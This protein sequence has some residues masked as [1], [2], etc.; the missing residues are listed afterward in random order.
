MADIRHDIFWHDMILVSQ[1]YKSHIVY[2]YYYYSYDV[3][4]GYSSCFLV[5][6]IDFLLYGPV[7]VKEY[8]TW[9]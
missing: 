9:K 6:M 4:H 1:S 3:I 5:E 7:H 8:L 2:L